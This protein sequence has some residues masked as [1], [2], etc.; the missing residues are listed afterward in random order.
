LKTP[1]AVDVDNTSPEPNEV[2]PQNSARPTRPS[3]GEGLVIDRRV[4]QLTDMQRLS[5][6]QYARI[7]RALAEVLSESPY[8]LTRTSKAVRDRV[9]S[10]TEKIS[11]SSVCFVLQRIT[12][13]LSLSSEVPDCRSAHV[14]A[15][16]FVCHVLA[17]CAHRKLE[18]RPEDRA[19]IEDWIIGGLSEPPSSESLPPEEPPAEPPAVS[20]QPG[21]TRE[22]AGPLGSAD[23]GA[24][25][26]LVDP[27]VYLSR[28][29]PLLREVEEVWKRAAVEP[30]LQECS[31]FLWPDTLASYR[32]RIRR[33]PSSSIRRAL[34]SRLINQFEQ[35][36]RPPRHVFPAHADVH[37][38]EPSSGP[39]TSISSISGLRVGSPEFLRIRLSQAFE[40]RH[41]GVWYALDNPEAQAWLEASWSRSVIAAFEM[42]LRDLNRMSQKL[43]LDRTRWDVIPI[44]ALFEQLILDILNEERPLASRAPLHEDLIEKTDL[45][46]S[47][48]SLQ[49]SGGARVQVTFITDEE[50]H[51]SKLRRIAH[52]E[53]FVVVSPL[54]LAGAVLGLGPTKSFTRTQRDAVFA[55]LGWPTQTAGVVAMALKSHFLRALGKPPSP[56]GPLLWIAPSIRHFIRVYVEREAHAAT[57]QVRRREAEGNAPRPPS[58]SGRAAE[59]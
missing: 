53:E 56:L 18:L 16:E 48:P 21:E 33:G 37:P 24:P 54:T 29:V 57:R 27:T 58:S 2:R 42:N 30:L 36:V 22:A 1:Q 9:V 49:G 26:P 19:R 3:G 55:S 14:L 12:R 23:P 41:W 43:W 50:R 45:R 25:P 44:G 15:Q 32:A 31:K 46:V 4:Q 11:R 20:P 10:S 7:F 38:C 28:V 47:Y 13:V 35:D 51:G 40:A 17:V 59:G 39:G 5:R 6:R 8:D 52:G 34:V